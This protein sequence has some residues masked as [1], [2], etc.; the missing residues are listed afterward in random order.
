MKSLIAFVALLFV[1]LAPSC[2]SYRGVAR[3]NDTVYLV[4]W[5]GFWFFGM[6][7][8]KECRYNASE[9]KLICRRVTIT[10]GVVP[11]SADDCKF[12]CCG[13]HCRP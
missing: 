2:V 1:V 12:C 11:Q 3:H 10:D 5:S 7:W 4:G 9:T 8:V 6:S 13:P